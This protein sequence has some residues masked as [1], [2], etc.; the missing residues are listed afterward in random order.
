[1]TAELLPCPFCGCV[2]AIIRTGN[3]CTKKRSVTIKCGGCRIERTDSA[4]R[5]DMDWLEGRA[6]GQWNTRVEPDPT[7]TPEYQQF[8]ASMV[9]HCRC[10]EGN[11]PCDGVL[12]GGPCDEVREDEESD[13]EYGEED[14]PK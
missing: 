12:A 11:R 2:P 6:V 1:M 9:P 5:N 14:E 7:N 8:V 10:K 4:L 3:D 13:R